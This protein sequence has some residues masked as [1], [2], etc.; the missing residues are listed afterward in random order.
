MVSIKGFPIFRI[1]IKSF[2][3]NIS[4]GS[5]ILIYLL[6]ASSSQLFQLVRVYLISFESFNFVQINASR[7][8][9]ISLYQA[10]LPNQLI[11]R[12]IFN[13]R[14]SKPSIL[15]LKIT[16]LRSK[17]KIYCSNWKPGRIN[18]R[19]P[20]GKSISYWIFYILLLP[21]SE[22]MGQLI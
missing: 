15:R 16:S 11:R 10:A 19:R 5:V 12:I 13:T 4:K 9:L 17:I 8:F 6:D 20:N 7:L 21:K 18:Q 22:I 14:E 3:T 1:L 2:Q